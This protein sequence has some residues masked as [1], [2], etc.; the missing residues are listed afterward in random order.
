MIS[1]ARTH[2][3]K[4]RASN[5]DAILVCPGKYGIYGVADG[6]GGHKAGDVASKIAVEV[7]EKA[8]KN[9]RPSIA[10]LRSAIQ[11]VNLAIYREQLQNPDFSGMGTTMT[12]IWEDDERVLLGHVGDSRAYRVREKSIRQISQ[13]HSMVAEMVRRGVLTEEEARVHPYRNIITRALG[14]DETVEVDAEE[15]DKRPGDLYL[16]CSDGLSEYVQ[17]ESLLY[18]LRKHPSLEEAADVLLNMALEGG[19]RDN[20]SVVLAEVTA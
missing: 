16:L 12:V 2:I 13:D 5:Q 11:E 1:A 19:G 20:I 3:G 8:L 17:N 10:L 15:L 4:V 14:T 7:T 6:M 9:A 18:I